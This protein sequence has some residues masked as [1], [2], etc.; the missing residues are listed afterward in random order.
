MTAETTTTTKRGRG[1][2]SRHGEAM[3][4]AQRQRRHR[5]ALKV[6]VETGDKAMRAVDA[7]L[8]RAIGHIEAGEP[9]RAAGVLAVAR[10]TLQEALEFRY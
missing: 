8:A 7:A 5:N 1:R 2:P 9:A 4:G 6:K 3:T 10:D